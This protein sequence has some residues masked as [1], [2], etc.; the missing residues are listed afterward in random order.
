MITVVVTTVAIAD[1]DFVGSV[2]DV[3]VRV[4]APPGGTA[5]GPTYVIG[6]PLAVCAVKLPQLDAAQLTD[7]STPATARSFATRAVTCV[8]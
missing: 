2:V 6:M 3:A 8:V 5:V 4:T 1:A 7:Q